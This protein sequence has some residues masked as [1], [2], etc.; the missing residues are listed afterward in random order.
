M[1]LAGAG[2]A[3]QDD[4]TLMRQEVTAGE[5]A[6]QRLI[7]RRVVGSCPTSWCRSGFLSSVGCVVRLPILA[8]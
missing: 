4:V 8:S 2:A 5:V 3:D 1:G 7:D 6:Y